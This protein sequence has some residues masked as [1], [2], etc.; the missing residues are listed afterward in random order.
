[1]VLDNN[2][3]LKGH[4]DAQGSSLVF[5]VPPYAT[6]TLA[7]LVIKDGAKITGN[8]HGGV[9]VYSGGSLVMEGGEISGNTDTKGGGV[10]IWG[11]SLVMNGGEISGNTAR[12]GGGVYTQGKSSV[13]LRGG[14]IS[15]NKGGIGGG[16]L[17]GTD[18]VFVMEGGEISGNTATGYGGGVFKYA[19]EVFSKTGGRI[20]GNTAEKE[21]IGANVYY[22]AATHYGYYYDGDLGEEDTISADDLSKWSRD[23]VPWL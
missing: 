19:G 23:N 22:L 8:S 11:G 10:Y 6:S 9:T 5:I 17:V 7:A 20:Y 1:M 13:T 18:T 12:Y 2:I 3:T 4:N 21:K 14:K 15:G 16:I